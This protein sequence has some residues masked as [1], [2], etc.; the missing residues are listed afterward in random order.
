MLVSIAGNAQ[1]ALETFGG[2][3]FPPTGWTADTNVATRPWRSTVDLTP[4]A[5]ATFNINGPSAFIDWIAQAQD[6]NL[7]SPSFSLVGFTAATFEFKA[8]IGYS[9]M[10]ALASGDLRARVSIDGGATWTIEWTEEDGGW[11]DDGD[12]DPDTDLYDTKTISLDMAPYL[13]QPNVRIRFNYFGND[14]DAVSVDDVRVFGSLG[15][16]EV[17]SSSFSTFP[18]P[19][20]DIITLTNSDN[21]TIDTILI[22]DINGRSIKTITVE[23]L[24][25]VQ[26]NVADLNSGIYFMNINSNAGKAVKKFIKN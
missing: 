11:L 9:Y 5:Q 12:G 24:S 2:A 6:A 4:A 23:N 10:I 3:T 26:I 15:V 17:L 22:T 20:N 1:L 19:V 7:T 13:G 25:E 14:A 21:A 16:N 8:K 18:N